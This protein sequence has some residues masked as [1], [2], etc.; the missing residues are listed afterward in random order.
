MD[1]SYLDKRVEGGGRNNVQL[2]F[3]PA[4]LENTPPVTQNKEPGENRNTKVLNETYKG[5]IGVVYAGF[6]QYLR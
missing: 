4:D 3:T 1:F 5:I 2:V 6:H